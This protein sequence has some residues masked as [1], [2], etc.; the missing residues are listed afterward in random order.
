MTTRYNNIASV[1]KSLF[2]TDR[3]KQQT[4][5][6]NVTGTKTRFTVNLGGIADSLRSQT[7]M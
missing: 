6:E 3:F 4:S 1:R 2:D 7:S 5:N